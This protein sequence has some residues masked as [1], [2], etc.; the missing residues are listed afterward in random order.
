MQRKQVDV[1]RGLDLTI[2]HLDGEMNPEQKREI[3]ESFMKK[4]NSEAMSGSH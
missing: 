2:L 1:L 3:D 4:V